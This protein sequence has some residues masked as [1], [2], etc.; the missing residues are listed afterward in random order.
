MSRTFART[1]LQG[2]VRLIQPL[3]AP[4][5][6]IEAR[7]CQSTLYN[8]WP[9]IPSIIVDRVERTCE[10]TPVS[11]QLH[12]DI[13]PNL[14]SGQIDYS[15][16]W[17]SSSPEGKNSDYLKFT[18]SSLD[19]THAT[20]ALTSYFAHTTPLLLARAVSNRSTRYSTSQVSHLLHHIFHSVDTM[21]L[22]QR[23]TEVIVMGFQCF[24][25]NPKVSLSYLRSNRLLVSLPSIYRQL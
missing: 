21:S 17:R 23:E 3:S 11:P 12:F 18:I 1:Q 25:D 13:N 5:N 6:I 9:G 10:K 8:R 15:K 22:T 4:D 2:I 24:K 20:S 14:T 7:Y 19:E 16:W